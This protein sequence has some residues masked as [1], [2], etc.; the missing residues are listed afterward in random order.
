MQYIILSSILFAA[1]YAAI[2]ESL[3]I[4]RIGIKNKN[5]IDVYCFFTSSSI[6]ILLNVFQIIS[7]VL[8]LYHSKYYGFPMASG[9][10]IPF[11]MA[12][13]IYFWLGLRR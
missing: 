9:V 8:D 7:L 12:F 1:A 5:I 10:A 2:D 13:S 4:F 6:L 11:F 3:S